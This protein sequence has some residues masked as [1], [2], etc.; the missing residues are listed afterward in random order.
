MADVP[1]EEQVE[2]AWQQIY[3][4]VQGMT[5]VGLRSLLGYVVG[6]AS[7]PSPERSLQTY[8][9]ILKSIADERGISPQH[10]KAPTKLA[11]KKRSKVRLVREVHPTYAAHLEALESMGFDLKRVITIATNAVWNVGTIHPGDKQPETSH[12]HQAHGRHD[13]MVSLLASAEYCRDTWEKN[14]R[15]SP[16]A[17]LWPDALQRVRVAVNQYMADYQ[18]RNWPTGE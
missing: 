14:H 18:K 10:Y 13:G 16:A 17:P 9:S 11:A 2:A 1:T 3:A 15:H 5:E 7:G 6:L 8:R 4:E 12:E